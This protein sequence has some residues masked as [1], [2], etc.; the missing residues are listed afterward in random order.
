MSELSIALTE[1]KSNGLC[2][3]IEKEGAGSLD[4]YIDTYSENAEEVC[5]MAARRLRRLADAFDRLSKM[6]N[7]CNPGTQKAAMI[8]CIGR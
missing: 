7:P 3:Y 8:A 1:Y 6:E 2:A 5:A 4:L